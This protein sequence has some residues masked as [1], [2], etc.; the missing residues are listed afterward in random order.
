MQR[1]MDYLLSIIVVVLLINFSIGVVEAKDLISQL[2]AASTFLVPPYTETDQNPYMPLV[3]GTTFVYKPVP[4]EENVVDTVVVTSDIKD[5]QIGADPL[6][7]YHCIVVR[8]YETVNGVPD[9]DTED[10]Y[11]LDKDGNVWYF[12][13]YTSYPSGSHEGSWTAGVDGAE[14]GYLMPAPAS[15][16]PGLSYR[17]EYYE[18]VA[19]DMGKVERLNAK[20][21]VAHGDFEDCLKTKEWSPLEPGGTEHKY[22]ARDIG[23]VLIEE[24]TGGKTVRM[25]LQ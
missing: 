11:A 6:N 10:W 15:L 18:G 19:E 12:G 13:E 21:S 14:P 17:Q 23:L 9:E 4:N 16:V 7:I 5:I 8:D 2:P 3:Q 1:L 22:Y 24:L 25:E 20:V